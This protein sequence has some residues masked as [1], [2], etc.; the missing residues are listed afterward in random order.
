MTVDNEIEEISGKFSF[1]D[2]AFEIS[3][4]LNFKEGVAEVS[5]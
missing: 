4:K 3:Y 2:C 5:Y 1:S